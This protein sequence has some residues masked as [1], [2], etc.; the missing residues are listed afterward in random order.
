MCHVLY[1]KARSGWILIKGKLVP[2]LEQ[3]D[4]KVRMSECYV[5][6]SFNTILKNK[7]YRRNEILNNVDKKPSYSLVTAIKPDM[8]KTCLYDIN[9]PYS[10]ENEIA[11]K[12]PLKVISP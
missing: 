7:M 9:L 11:R 4:E 10:Y 3:F 5:K 12:M 8:I 2:V 1:A 6:N